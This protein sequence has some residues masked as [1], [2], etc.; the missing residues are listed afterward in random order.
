MSA[1]G[2][3]D[4]RGSTIMPPLRHLRQEEKMGK[5]VWR[6]AV[7][8]RRRRRAWTQGAWDVSSGA[9]KQTLKDGCPRVSRKWARTPRAHLPH[10][11]SFPAAQVHKTET[12]AM[13][14][15]QGDNLIKNRCQNSPRSM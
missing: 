13:S 14:Y 8:K 7:E 15:I 4:L 11:F 10:P 12:P 2:K 3:P 5:Q 9:L 1:L 6:G